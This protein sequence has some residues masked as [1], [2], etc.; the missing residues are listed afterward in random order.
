M[1][2]EG[3]GTCRVCLSVCV[4]VL[5]LFYHSNGG[6]AE[7]YAQTKVHMTSY[8]VSFSFM[9]QL[10]YSVQKLWCDLAFWAYRII[11]WNWSNG[12]HFDDRAFYTC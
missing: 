1:R 5:H 9:V 6:M 3:Y 10:N 12:F 11:P 7:F 2:S 4:S 8:N